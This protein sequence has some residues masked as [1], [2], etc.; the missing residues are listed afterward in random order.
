MYLLPA[1]NA[2]RAARRLRD[3]SMTV[4][5]VD[6]P[7]LLPGFRGLPDSRHALLSFS[8][9]SLAA[10]AASTVLDDWA[11][12]RAHDWLRPELKRRIEAAEMRGLRIWG[13]V[14]IASE[15]AGNAVMLL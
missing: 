7:L 14:D 13:S 3:L 2:D 8:A 5:R 10:Q 15:A 1:E 6:V 9:P 4:V 12:Q 11:L